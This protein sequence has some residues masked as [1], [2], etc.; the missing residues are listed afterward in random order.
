MAGENTAS[1]L[2]MSDEDFM[3]QDESAFM[4][5]D[6]VVEAEGEASEELAEGQTSAEETSGQTEEENSEAQEHTEE[7][8]DEEEVGQLDGDT[9]QELETSS[10]GDESES[11]DTGDEDS[12]ETNGDTQD[13]TEFNYESAY[14][15]VTK[16]FKANGS[17]MQVSDPQDIVRLMQMGANYQKKMAQMKPNLKV[18]KMLENNG[19]L[20]EAKLHNLIDLSKKDPVAVA[21][22]I[23]ESGI[24][25][26]DVDTDASTDDYKPTDYSV[27]DK[28]YDLDQVLDGIKESPSFSK[29][30]D[31]LTKEWDE[32]SKATVSDNPTI[33]S[34][35]NAHME[36][37]VYDKVNSV[38]QQEKALGR[39]DGI[40]DVDAY[41]Q[42][43]DQ[44]QKDGILEPVTDS[45]KAA[46]VSQENDDKSKADAERKNKRNAAAPAKHAPSGKDKGNSE[47]FLGLS[48]DEFM[49]KYGTT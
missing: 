14:K 10:E 17:D 35:I 37:G 3:N 44:L 23:K 20:D 18:I 49:K 48:D 22:L 9:Q 21:K 6:P 39:L 28:E 34:V 4:A 16:P 36:N 2:T 38:M 33:I 15:E 19:L 47:D 40:S 13:T 11:P 30:I 1:A 25:P 5:D 24:D 26:L 29:T 12:T 46:N 42:I 41:K 32:G 31:V 43:A 45:P 8:A 27:S 7:T